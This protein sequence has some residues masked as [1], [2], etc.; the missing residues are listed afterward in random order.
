[1]QTQVLGG[2]AVPSFGHLHL[3]VYNACGAEIDCRAIDARGDPRHQL[4]DEARHWECMGWHVRRAMGMSYLGFQ[5]HR[6]GEKVSVV[7]TNQATLPT[8]AAQP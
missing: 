1:M 3:R 2:T 4:A 7:V 5:A 6:H 8:R